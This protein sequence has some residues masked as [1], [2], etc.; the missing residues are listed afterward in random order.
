MCDVTENTMSGNRDT[1]IANTYG[2]QESG[3]T[4]QHTKSKINT[5]KSTIITLKEIFEQEKSCPPQQSTHKKTIFVIIPPSV[6]ICFLLSPS[7]K[8]SQNS[9]FLVIY[10]NFGFINFYNYFIKIF[11]KNK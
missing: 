6:K 1:G 3:A 2:H 11:S 7:V 8:H 5:F 9:S 10:L 4:H